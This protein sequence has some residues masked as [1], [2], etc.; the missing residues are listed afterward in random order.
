MSMTMLK[1]SPVFPLPVAALLAIAAAALPGMA[2][3]APA[4]ESAYPLSPPVFKTLIVETVHRF[5]SPGI[6]GR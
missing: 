4:T 6:P 2:G 5:P 1:W 3:A